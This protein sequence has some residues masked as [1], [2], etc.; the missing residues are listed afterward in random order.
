MLEVGLLRITVLNEP[1][2]FARGEF[3]QNTVADRL[4]QLFYNEQL[5]G[6]SGSPY[7]ASPSYRCLGW[8]CGH[9]K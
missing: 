7:S 5:N 9:C 6:I 2:N 4:K 1:L 3:V 8:L